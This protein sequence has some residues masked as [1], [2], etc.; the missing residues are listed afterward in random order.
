MLKKLNKQ[1]VL[2]AVIM[3][4]TFF[5]ILFMVGCVNQNEEISL[6]EKSTD[7]VVQTEEISSGK[8]DSDGKI[9]V[10]IFGAVKKPGVYAVAE[11]SRVYEVI[12]LAGGMTK[13]AKKDCLNQAET[14]VDSQNIQVLTKKQYRNMQKSDDEIKINDNKTQEGK[15][16]INSADVSALMQLNGIGETKAKAIVA[17]R[18]E[19]GNFAKVED[20]KNVSG[21]GD[22]T[23]ASISADITVD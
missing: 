4:N 9:Y 1:Y 17:Y 12:E 19:N 22:A 20:I 3:A 10:Y 14:V 5:C 8:A 16:N 6:K 18:K 2:L 15:I 13:S 21:I 11:G 23:F 7:I